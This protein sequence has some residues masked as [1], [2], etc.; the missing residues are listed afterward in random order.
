MRYGKGIPATR[1]SYILPA[2]AVAFGYAQSGAT[3]A[4]VDRGSDFLVT[5]SGLD[6]SPPP[7]CPVTP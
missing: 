7:W 5:A 3:I 4:E 2:L 6:Q 1:A